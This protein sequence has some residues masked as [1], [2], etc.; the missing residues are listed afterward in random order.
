MLRWSSAVS[1]GSLPATKRFVLDA[2]G[3]RVTHVYTMAGMLEL[4]Q[5]WNMDAPD[6][7]REEV[8]A[9]ARCLIASSWGQARTLVIRKK[10]PALGLSELVENTLAPDGASLIAAMSTTVDATGET[11]ATI[12]RFVR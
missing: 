3:S 9:G 4:T 5:E 8:E 11:R 1:V 10:F 12:D 6:E 7:W 2:C